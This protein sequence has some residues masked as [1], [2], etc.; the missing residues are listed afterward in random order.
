MKKYKITLTQEQIDRL[1]AQIQEMPTKYG[2]PIIQLLEGNVFLA[3]EESD[4][5]PIG[6]GGGAGAP[7][8]KPKP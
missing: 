2:L 5:Q 3:E 6:G 1:N 4:P 8:P 7:K